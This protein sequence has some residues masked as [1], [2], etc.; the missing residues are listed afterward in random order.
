VPIAVLMP[1]AAADVG[2]TA[3]PVTEVD[4]RVCLDESAGVPPKI[5]RLLR[6]CALMPTAPCRAVAERIADNRRPADCRNPERQHRVG[7][8]DDHAR[9][10]L[11]GANRRWK[12][13]PSL[14]ALDFA[15]VAHDVIVR[16]ATLCRR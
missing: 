4:R 11:I 9:L 7:P 10:W 14:R 12:R 16:D 8:F 2:T 5:L 15:G 1:M 3:R 13:R 6:P